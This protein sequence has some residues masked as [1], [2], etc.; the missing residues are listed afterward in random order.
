VLTVQWTCGT[1][2]QPAIRTPTPCTERRHRAFRIRSS[3]AE[4]EVID[5]RGAFLASLVDTEE[6]VADGRFTPPVCLLFTPSRTPVDARRAVE[7]GHDQAHVVQATP[8]R[9]AWA[10]PAAALRRA[11][12]CENEIAAAQSPRLIVAQRLRPVVTS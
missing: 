1:P 3:R 12:Q 8:Q 7:V 9:W 11:P 6:L 5:L 4:T 2:S 10:V